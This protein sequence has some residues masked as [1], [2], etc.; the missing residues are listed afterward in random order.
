M[1]VASLASLGFVLFTA[2]GVVASPVDSDALTSNDLDVRSEDSV[3]IR[4]DG[5]SIE[6]SLNLR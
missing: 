3:E 2:M 5:V 4:Y 6:R 1:K